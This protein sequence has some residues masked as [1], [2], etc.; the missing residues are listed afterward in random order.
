MNGYLFFHL[1]LL[2]AKPRGCVACTLALFQQD[3][4]CVPTG[5]VTHWIAFVIICGERNPT[6]NV[7]FK[8]WNVIYSLHCKNK[9]VYT[10]M[11]QEK[12]F[13]LSYC[14]KEYKSKIHKKP[15]ASFT[16]NLLLGH[17]LNIKI[18]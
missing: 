17:L 12:R 3:T 9:N 15:Q 14:V 2:G 7:T 18:S 11:H 13:S 16:K 1:W 6:A 10:N 8:L 4:G 5:S